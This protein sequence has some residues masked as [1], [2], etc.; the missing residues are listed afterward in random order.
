MNLE[1]CKWE[2]MV[3]HSARK[4]PSCRAALANFWK[5]V[6]WTTV[7]SAVRTASAAKV[8]APDDPSGV[9]PC[10]L[11]RGL[12]SAPAAVAPGLTGFPASG[13]E[14]R[15]PCRAAYKEGGPTFL[16]YN[17]RS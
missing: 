14:D 6:T 13:M 16:L 5:P 3:L 15:W 10:P 12:A 7:C 2:L 17:L 8:Q 9:R 4:V 11:P 1:T